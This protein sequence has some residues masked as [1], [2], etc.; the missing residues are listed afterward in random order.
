MKLKT[1]EIEG[2]TYAAV[3]D[4][5]P[6]YTADDGKEVAFDAP[7]TVA[8]I[9]R[10]N[11]EAKGHRE[12]KEA[13]EA[14]LKGFDGLNDPKAALQAL[15]TIRN[16]DAKKLVDA[17][18]VEKV[19]AEA[20]KAVE[21]KYA[22]SI[23]AAEERL[24]EVAKARDELEGQLY[25][26]KIGGSFARSKFAA[27]KLAIPGDLVQSRFGQNFKIEDG[28][29]VAYDG[30]G[31]RVYSRSKPGEVADFEEAL[32]VLVDQYPYRDAIMKGSGNAGGAAN[33]GGRGM[34]AGSKTISRGAFEKM[35]PSD[36]QSKMREGFK[37]T[38]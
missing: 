5:K 30:S 31:N 12:A 27:E 1:V 34:D 17:G 4:G 33:G 19:K 21:E 3:Q 14:R 8:T 23:K 25:S 16:L 37:V 26:E 20:I 32:E 29:I 11:G 9:S 18:E 10:L 38:D 13:A 15:E 6:V 36:Q 35:P 2:T 7:S 28:K 24:A 22:S